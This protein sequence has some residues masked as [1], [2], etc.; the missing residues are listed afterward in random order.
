M[1]CPLACLS[2]LRGPLLQVEFFLAADQFHFLVDTQQSQNNNKDLLPLKSALP[3]F[4]LDT[5]LC[6]HLRQGK[7]NS[8]LP[9]L[10]NRV[11]LG[12]WHCLFTREVS[13][14]QAQTCA[15]L[16]CVSGLILGAG[17]T[18]VREP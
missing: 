8:S 16:F 13:K 2:S 4:I 7:F 11:V 17:D 12:H 1:A 15:E 18:E 10:E 9:G 3:G 14:S 6:T 5:L